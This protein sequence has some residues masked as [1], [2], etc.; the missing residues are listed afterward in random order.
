MVDITKNK[1]DI[2]DR[3]FVFSKK[4]VIWVKNVRVDSTFQSLIRQLV[5]SATSISANMMEAS[6]AESKKDFISKL[7]ISI[8]EAKESLYWIKLITDTGLV[9]REE[10]EEIFSECQ[11][12]VKVL[13]AIKN[14]TVK[15][16][17]K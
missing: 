1:I 4:V 13:G 3:C 9:D 14:S 17:K 5:R 15:N 10:T 7:S 16:I 2:Y 8:K 11:E 12:L 6:E